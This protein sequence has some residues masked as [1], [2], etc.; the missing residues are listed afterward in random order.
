MNVDTQRKDRRRCWLWSSRYSNPCSVWHGIL[1]SSFSLGSAVLS[2][3]KFQELPLYPYIVKLKDPFPAFFFKLCQIRQDSA[4]CNQNKFRNILCEAIL[5]FS[6]WNK[7]IYMNK[8]SIL[9]LHS[10]TIYI[11]ILGP[12]P[13][14]HMEVPRLGSNWSYSCWPTPLLTATLDPYPTEWGQES[15]PHPHGS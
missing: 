15:N 6:Y 14:W 2:T 9:F 5:Y 3:L 13:L 10:L 12:Q 1:G 11:Y 8:Y 4:A 7:N